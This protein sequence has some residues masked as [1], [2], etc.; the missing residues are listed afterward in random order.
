[1]PLWTA[2]AADAEPTHYGCNTGCTDGFAVQVAI[3][4]S[5]VVP[6]GTDP[7]LTAVALGLRQAHPEF[8]AALLYRVCNLADYASC[9]DLLCQDAGLTRVSPSD[10]SED[11]GV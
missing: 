7:A 9:F 8:A 6:P 5:G 10:G 1:V 11:G 3:V 2:D 4:S